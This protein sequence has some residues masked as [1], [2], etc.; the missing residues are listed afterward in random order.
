M[1]HSYGGVVATLVADRAP[2][3]VARL[4]Y[5]DAPIP[6][7]GQ[8]LLDLLT[9]MAAADFRE[10]AARSDGWRVPPN[11]PAALGI[12]DSEDAAWAAPRLTPRSLAT[13]TQPV[14]LTSVV[15]RVP[16]AYIFLRPR[17][18]GQHPR[19][20]RRAGEGGRVGLRRDHCRARRDA[21]R[22]GRPGRDAARLGDGAAVGSWA[23]RARG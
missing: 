15:E 21:R 7:D 6:D 9:P 17:P 5:L 19:P 20:V 4:V 13:F 2:E 22:A 1:G 18:T 11:T 10:R 16:R 12:D 23:G 8:C 14:R 3:R